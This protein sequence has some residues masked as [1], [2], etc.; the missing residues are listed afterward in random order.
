MP[1]VNINILD[2][3]S[4]VTTNGSDVFPTVQGTQGRKTTVDNLADY[5]LSDY[6]L[7]FSASVV[8]NLTRVPTVNSSTGD[9]GNTTLQ[10]LADYIFTDAVMAAGQD[11]DAT[12][13]SGLGDLEFGVRNPATGDLARVGLD[14]LKN[15]VLIS[16]NTLTAQSGLLASTTKIPTVTT[17]NVLRSATL[18]DIHSFSNSVFAGNT[19]KSS[20]V[21]EDN[22]IIYDFSTG[23]ARRARMDAIAE[24]THSDI[25]TYSFPGSL[26]TTDRMLFVR[27]STPHNMTVQ[28]LHDYMFNTLFPAETTITTLADND[29]ILVSDTSASGAA[30]KATLSSLGTYFSIQDRPITK[31]LASATSIAA[32]VTEEV[33]SFPVIADRQYMV[34]GVIIL[35]S[36][37]VDQTAIRIILTAGTS[38][39]TSVIRS[40]TAQYVNLAGET[41]MESSTSPVVHD[42]LVSLDG[43]DILPDANGRA[44][45]RVFGTIT[46]GVNDSLGEVLVFNATPGASTLTLNR[47][48]YFTISSF[49]Q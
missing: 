30:S 48:S 38:S 20:L 17:G 15:S 39:A 10:F 37:N 21:A 49:D 40:L 1:D 12:P 22:T 43:G 27:G 41:V 14:H 11:M 25:S 7:D 24:Y 35:S 13:A 47:G 16:T 4:V 19:L 34:E 46:T 5:T 6:V 45:I 26:Q 28:N 31:A 3:D 18:S 9:V 36:L 2:L 44:V 29:H 32:L 33:V 42:V 23:L 8:S